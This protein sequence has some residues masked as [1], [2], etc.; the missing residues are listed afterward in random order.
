MTVCGSKVLKAYVILM[1]SGCQCHGGGGGGRSG[2]G[3]IPPPPPSPRCV[4]FPF[5]LHWFLTFFVFIFL[6]FF[7]SS[8]FPF[9]F[10]PIFFSP[11]FIFFTFIFKFFFWFF[12]FGLSAQSPVMYID[13]N[14]PNPLWW[15]CHP[16]FSGRGNMCH[17]PH[18]SPPPPFFF[19]ACPHSQRAQVSELKSISSKLLIWISRT[20]G[21]TPLGVGL[22]FKD[23]H[24][25]CSS[26]WSSFP[27]H[28]WNLTLY[29][30][31]ATFSLNS[32]GNI[33]EC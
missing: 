9:F 26:L 28:Y 15:F 20:A 10:S 24:Q 13:D 21:E 32:T 12:F 14:T 19:F 1:W 16:F 27:S 4:F 7:F 18:P 6:N 31:N 29:A 30:N 22:V 25:N 33:L 2:H 3:G 11:L 23:T 17:S 8:F 5:F